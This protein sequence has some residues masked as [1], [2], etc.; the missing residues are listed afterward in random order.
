VDLE[1]TPVT[2]LAAVAAQSD[3][4]PINI[5]IKNHCCLINTSS[6]QQS[7]ETTIPTHLHIFQTVVEPGQSRAAAC[8]FT[9]CWVATLALLSKIV[10]SSSARITQRQGGL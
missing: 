10:I 1:S 4:T 3:Y 7:T 5:T 8:L 2:S 9:E 6:S